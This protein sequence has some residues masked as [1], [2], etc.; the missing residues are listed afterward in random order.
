MSE[1]VVTVEING[2]PL[3]ARKGAMI[4]EVADA[5]GITIPRF[6][7]HKKLSIAANCRM[8]LVEVEKMLKP[9]PACATP[10]LEGMMVFTD[11]PRAIAAQKATMEFLLINHPLDCPICD[12]GGEC[13]L[14]DVAMGYGRDISRFQE[15]KRVV[16]DKDIGPLITTE[17]TRCIHCTR[18]VR[19]GEEIAGLRE[20]G[21]TG[22]GEHME[23]GTYIAKSIVSELSG[24]VIDLCPVGALTAK[25][26]RYTGRSWEYV[27]HAGVSPHDSVG[28]N[29]YLHT[30]RGK[31]MRV[32]PRENEA[33]NEVWLADRDRFSYQGIYSADRALRPLIID[34]SGNLG[35]GEWSLALETV[36][37]GL[38]AVIDKHGAESVGFLVSPNATLEEMY[39]FQKLARG[40]GMANIDH[41]LRQVDF[42]DQDKAPVFPWLG[43]SLEE[44]QQLDAALL[45]GS[46]IRMEQPLA[47]HRIRKAALAGAKIMLINFR[48][49]AFRF[50]VTAK[51]ITDPFAMV[52]TLQAVARAVAALKGVELPADLKPLGTMAAIGE[53]ELSMAEHLVNSARAAVLLGNMAIAHPA[54]SQLRALAVFIARLS[55]ARL[56]YLPE[57]ANSVGAWLAGALPHRGVGGQQAPVVGLD[58]HAMLKSPCKAYVLLGFEPEFDCWD[59][60]LAL[61]ALTAAD[62]VVSLTAYVPERSKQY[63]HVVLPTA[64]FAETP[65]T[66]V[67]V[68]GRWQSVEAAVNPP[69]EARPAWKILRV[70]G[71]TFELAGFDYLDSP[72]VLAEIE[73]Q[74]EGIEPQNLMETQAR[75]ISWSATDLWRV[76]EVPIYAV[77]PLVRRAEALQRTPLARPA[78]II[79]NPLLAEKLGLAQA[80]QA[81]LRQ[82]GT[83]VVLPLVLDEGIP[84]GCVWVSSG[85]AGS[86]SLGPA[87]GAVELSAV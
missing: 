8:C 10:V 5:A 35:V 58:A 37:A 64:V 51:V 21:A 61:S 17:M 22:R 86:A 54:F 38:R 6:C 79:L 45:V 72:T 74:C 66:Y 11:S 85:L 32:V 12:Q 23:I 41:R 13:E 33:V 43:Q 83:E 31:V 46:N 4:I 42:S 73:A 39:L 48:D 62:F 18:C 81:R 30:I 71:N 40:L 15:R 25:P 76:S 20:L 47:G 63:V 24:N 26:S 78:E 14:Q 57:A 75:P 60:S 56:G 9:M 16:K 44:L 52:S 80:S 77:D 87:I 2:I 67:N 29:L 27:Q 59:P 50:P 36:R 65:G 68:E 55:G 19:F 53:A 28:S 3:Q 84:Q 49:F 70:L 69:G 7:Y 1:E 34:N 82:N